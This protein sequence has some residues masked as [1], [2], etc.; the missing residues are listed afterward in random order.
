M[1]KNNKKSTSDFSVKHK[2]MGYEAFLIGYIIVVIIPSMILS[3]G[4]Y[5]FIN[6]LLA[7]VL[8]ALV[9]FSY[10]DKTY[11]TSISWGMNSI[12]TSQE[13]ERYFMN[14]HR[15]HFWKSMDIVVSYNIQ[16][17][18]KD[19]V[20]EISVMGKIGSK[21]RIL[22][23]DPESKYVEIVEKASGMKSGEYAYYALQIQNFMMR[24][25]QTSVEDTVVDI[26]IKYYDALPLDNMLRAYDV[27]FAYDSKQGSENNFMSYS[28]EHD[29]NGYNFYR[30]L[31]EE[32]WKDGSFCYN[33]E[34]TGDMVPNFAVLAESDPVSYNV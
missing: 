10:F 2:A 32:K 21:I 34:I 17:F 5:A 29:L 15:M 20:R 1:R 12:Y 30:T 8:V 25:E 16:A 22:L 24:V 14:Y 7:L 18:L 6:V 26:E 27:V 33:K 3:S 28:F 13:S 23:L 9:L 4:E 11:N 19:K 31:F